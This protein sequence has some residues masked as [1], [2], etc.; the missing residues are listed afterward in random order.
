MKITLDGKTVTFT[1]FVPKNKEEAKQ[2]IEDQRNLMAMLNRTPYKTEIDSDGF[3]EQ[4]KIIIDMDTVEQL[5][6][7][8]A[9]QA[10]QQKEI[11]NKLFTGKN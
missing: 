6:E 10:K 7:K 8:E 2:V 3:V 9:N 1:F 11:W 4:R 5:E